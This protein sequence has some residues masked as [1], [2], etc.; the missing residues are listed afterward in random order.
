VAASLGAGAEPAVPRTIRR[1][2][3]QKRCYVEAIVIDGVMLSMF[4][5]QFQEPQGTPDFAA[6]N[7]LRSTLGTESRP[8]P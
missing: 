4:S 7:P 1:E 3:D 6:V 5:K 8:V 2:P